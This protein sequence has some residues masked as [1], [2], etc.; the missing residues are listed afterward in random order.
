MKRIYILLFVTAIALSGC[1]DYLD[2]VPEGTSRLEN[3]FAR[4]SE[5]IK[6]LFTCYSY[7]PKSGDPNSDPAIWGDEMWTMTNAGYYQIGH[8]AFN[9]ARN[10]QSPQNPLIDRWGHYYRAIR[11]CNIFLENINSVPDMPSWERTQWAAEVT[12][13][14]AY[15][16]YMLVLMYGPV[17]I[18]R[19]NLPIDASQEQVRVF[20]EPID[21]CFEYI[22]ELLDEAKDELPLNVLSP[23]TELGRITSP[24]AYALK[25]KV[26]VTAAS[27]LFNGNTDQKTLVNTRSSDKTP[28]FNQTYSVK[29]WELAADACLEAI[30]ICV[31]E[32]GMKLYE[33]PGNYQ[34][35]L[36]AT[37]KQDLTLRCAFNQRWNN[38]TIWANTQSLPNYIQMGT[39]PRLN[40]EY[41]AGAKIAQVF[42]VPLK[43]AD[44]FYSENGV[45]YDDDKTIDNENRLKLRQSDA[46][47]ELYIRRGRKTANLHFDRE[48]RYYAWLGFESGIWYGQ[49]Q[50]D[51]TKTSDLFWVQG[52]KGQI[53]GMTGPDFGPVTGYIPKK[54]VY[55]ENVQTSAVDGYD[56]TGYPWPLIRLSDLFLLYAEALN[57]SEDSQTNRNAAMVYLDKV[58]ARAGLKG[59]EYS[60]SN[61]SKRNA[62][63]YLRQD[64]LRTIIQRERL[65][66][67]AFEGQRFWDI[68]RWKTAMDQYKTPIESW[69]LTQREAEYY[70]RKK[71]LFNQTFTMKDYF[72]PIKTNDLI[73]NPNLEQNI[74][75]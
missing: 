52:L 61:F 71:V 26:L 24:I 14:K 31:D 27:P 35:N 10:L 68:R 70:Y 3:V 13:L 73:V 1:A 20:R 25:A 47:T 16:H 9:I 51:D 19:K 18:I 22:V 63:A 11:D 45:P 46:S 28:L 53:H 44:Q 39:T 36:S 54:Y 33:Y 42:A 62:G 8:E 57:E 58:R 40:P 74:G 72:W 29:K 17:P 4:R 6:Y 43:I 64:G 75:W 34:Y 60:W 59:V 67:L 66:E 56:I 2:V 48:P 65:I 30:N 49:G 38:E 55:Y 32:L 41:Q 21:D 15:Y 5:T 37:I 69:D 12:F 23:V 50:Y 7:M